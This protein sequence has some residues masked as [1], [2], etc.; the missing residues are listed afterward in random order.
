MIS[1][2]TWG[3][4][5]KA[6]LDDPPG[7]LGA[8]WSV[9]TGAWKELS[10]GGMHAK[11]LQQVVSIIYM[12]GCGWALDL[13]RSVGFD[14]TKLAPRMHQLPEPGC[15]RFELAWSGPSWIQIDKQMEVLASYFTN[16]E[17]FLMFNS[18]TKQVQQNQNSTVP[19]RKPGT[20][21]GPSGASVSLPLGFCERSMNRYHHVNHSHHYS[22]PWRA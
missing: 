16:S 2:A 7:F 21:Q 15:Q 6:S 12:S 3:Q 14:C 9:T 17:L 11:Q 13:N 22:E 19:S 18:G 1:C 20:E 4:Y 5:W 8:G 10:K